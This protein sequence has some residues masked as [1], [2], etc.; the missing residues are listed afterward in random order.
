MSPI[1]QIIMTISI[2]TAFTLSVLFIYILCNLI[3]MYFSN[4]IEGV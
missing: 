3:S 2:V 4:F 1:M